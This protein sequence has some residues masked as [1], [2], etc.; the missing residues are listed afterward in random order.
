MNT[1]EELT[2]IVNYLDRRFPNGNEIFQRVSRLAEETGELAQV[3]NH[4]EGM[5]M[6]HEKYGTP[7]KE[8]LAKEIQ[9]VIRAALGIA[10]HYHVEELLKR[11]IHADYKKSQKKV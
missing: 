3:V 5:G 6:K 10:K 7:D 11:S 1:Y 8:K 2:E 9:D 4:I